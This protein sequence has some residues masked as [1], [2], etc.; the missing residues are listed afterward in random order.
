LEE[1]DPEAW[2]WISMNI[3]RKRELNW[4]P[5]EFYKGIKSLKQRRENP[6]RTGEVR[7]NSPK[8]LH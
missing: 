7:C 2:R 8:G 3:S 6:Q 4:S 5:Q 1:K